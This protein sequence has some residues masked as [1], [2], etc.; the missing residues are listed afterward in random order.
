ML[1]YPRKNTRI[2]TKMGKIHELFVLALFLVWFAG[3]I[4][5]IRVAPLQNEIDA[6]HF[7]TSKT[8]ISRRPPDYSSNLCPPKTFAI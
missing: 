7:L 8:N 1:V 5:D 3:A 4:P 2:H 6:K